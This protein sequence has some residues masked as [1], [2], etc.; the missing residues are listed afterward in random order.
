M[1]NLK[2]YMIFHLNL[3]FSSIEEDSRPDTI[4]S[5]YYPL[6][7]LIENS[8]HPIGIEL[9]GWTLKEIN[10]LDNAWI[11]KFK[12]L[13]ISG[14]CE[15]IGSGYSQIIGPLVPYSVNKWNQKLGIDTYF[16][17]LGI[18]PE[19]VLVNEMAYSTSLVNLYKEFGYKGLIMDRDNVKLSLDSEKLPSHA[20]GVGN[21]E[22][23]ILWSDTT[24]FQKMQYYAYG[25]ISINDYLDYLNKRANEGDSLFPIYCNDAEVF[26]YRPGRFKEERPTHPDGEWARIE[27]LLSAL[28][29]KINMEFVKPSDALKNSKKN[30]KILGALNSAS[31]PIPVKKQAKY[32]ISRWAVTGRNDLWLN[33]MCYRIEKELTI[34]KNNDSKEWKKLCY[35]WSSDF[36]THITKK[37]W[38]KVNNKMGKFLKKY[39]KSSILTD[40]IFINETKKG[41]KSF[42]GKNE[43]IEIS[44]SEDKIFLHIVT[45]NLKLILNLRRGLAIKNLA[46]SSHKFEECIGT[47]SH[48]YFSSISLGADF[49]SG[50]TVI[51]LPTERTRLTDLEKVKPMIYEKSNG[52]VQICTEIKTSLGVITKSIEVSAHDEKISLNYGFPDWPELIGS[53]RLGIVTMLNE[54]AHEETKLSFSNGGMHY[55]TMDFTGQ[56]NHVDSASFLTSSSGGI[57]AT[58]GKIKINNKNKCINLSWDPSE[59]AVMPMLQKLTY[60]DKSLCRVYFSMKETDDTSKIPSKISKFSLDIHA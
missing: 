41:L 2:G 25:D 4:K 29:S 56:I 55:E 17:I 51:E 43:D 12:T 16:Q 26:D 32:N 46:F 13:L 19:L 8:K 40:D 48:G 54:F 30:K 27:K 14:K 7:N 44:L 45:K 20:R 35:L 42:T 59:S 52:D 47:L 15:L 34:L 23:P 57:G 28:S 1:K 31:H 50:G 21:Q 9:T 33:T 3:G 10:K 53:F 36:R 22:I 39:G 18:R 11:K 24:L 38:D 6:L 37:R 49:Y 60:E 5:C 58:D